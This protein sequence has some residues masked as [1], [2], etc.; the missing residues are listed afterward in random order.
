MRDTRLLM[1]SGMTPG[2]RIF[3]PQLAAIP[4]MRVASWLPPLRNETLGRYARRLADSLPGSAPSFLGGVSFGG[5]VA[6]ELA[7]LLPVRACFLISSVTSP[8]ELPP[9]FRAARAMGPLDLEVVLQGAGQL[10]A[11]WPRKHRSA[12]TSRLKKLAGKSGD[13]HRWATSAV[14]R[15]RPNPAIA[16]LKIYRIHGQ[17][18]RTLPSRYI[19]GAV[20]IPTG[21]HV[22]PLTHPETINRFITERMADASVAREDRT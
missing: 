19:R 7:C 3:A 17:L 15:W 22:L 4:G 8:S 13:W 18:D 21:G 6:L 14:L 20:L 11:A 10:A 16:N 5:I 1:F 12:A 9:W 2:E